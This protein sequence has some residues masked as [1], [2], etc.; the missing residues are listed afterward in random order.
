M[1]NGRGSSN[2]RLADVRELVTSSVD[3]H[4]GAPTRT[5]VLGLRA[6]Q[7]IRALLFERMP[8]P[9]G[10]AADRKRRREERYIESQSV[11]HERGV[12][13]H[14]RLQPAAWLLFFEQRRANRIIRPQS[15][16]VGP[17]GRVWVPASQRSES[18]PREA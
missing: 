8:D 4:P 12:E 15:E 10:D 18:I 13:L 3:R 2:S 9:P 11:Q 6:D 5:H 7:A 14:V 16:Y 17:L 1:S